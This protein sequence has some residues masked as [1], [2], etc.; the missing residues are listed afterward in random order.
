M[1]L[2]KFGRNSDNM[3]IPSNM[4]TNLTVQTDAQLIGSEPFLC[5]WLEKFI[6]EIIKYPKLLKSE[7]TVRQFLAIKIMSLEVAIKHSESLTALESRFACTHDSYPQLLNFLKNLTRKSDRELD[8]L[9]PELSKLYGGRFRFG[10]PTDVVLA[11]CPILIV[12][13]DVE[14]TVCQKLSLN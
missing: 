12:R 7:F 8:F 3:L 2:F 6:E 10:T 9:K 4:M 11:T 5:S 1:A 14:F 13:M